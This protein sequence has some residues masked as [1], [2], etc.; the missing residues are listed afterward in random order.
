M[1][2]KNGGEPVWDPVVKYFLCEC[3]KEYRGNHCE[4]GNKDILWP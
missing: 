1:E 4:Y 3:P 2:C